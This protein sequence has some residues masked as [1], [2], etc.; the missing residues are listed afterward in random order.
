MKTT[1]YHRH[2]GCSQPKKLLRSQRGDISIYTCFFLVGIVMLV[3]FLLLYASIRITCINIRNGAK[4]ELNNLSASIYADTFRS[5]RE[6]NFSEYLNTL[7]SSSS[8]TAMLEETVTD[9]L[10]N[11]IP[12]S[13]DDYQVRDISLSFRVEGDRLEYIFSCEVEFYIHMF[14]HSYPAIT[15]HVELTGFHNTKF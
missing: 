13:T 15:R 9:G 1:F 4:M 7:Y 2:P 10:A 3:S 8:Y 6:S 11:K 14:G 5:Q 12:L